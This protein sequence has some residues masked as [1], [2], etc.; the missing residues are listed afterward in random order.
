M[1]P[2]GRLQFALVV[3]DRKVIVVELLDATGDSSKVC[4]NRTM[5]PLQEG[6]VQ[7]VL[8]LS[9]RERAAVVINIG[10]S[11]FQHPGAMQTQ[12]VAKQDA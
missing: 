4:R 9:I 7:A 3:E 6:F 12:A 2:R 10:S 5:R 11:A 8:L 1:L